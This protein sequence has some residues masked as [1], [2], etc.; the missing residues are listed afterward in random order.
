MK[1]GIIFRLQSFWIGIHYSPYNKRFC[2]NP[3]PCITIWII[4]EGGIV[5]NKHTK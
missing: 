1:S 3:L 2:I 5:P 4:L